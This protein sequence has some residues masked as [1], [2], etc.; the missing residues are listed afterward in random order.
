MDGFVQLEQ[1]TPSETRPH[2]TPP[3]TP[4]PADDL[5]RSPV[6]ARVLLVDD[7]ETTCEVL[8]SVLVGAGHEAAWDSD[9]EKALRR[10]AEEEFDVVLTDLSM[11]GMDG[12]QLCARIRELN[13]NLPVIVFTGRASIDAAVGALRAGA[14]DFLQ[15]PVEANLMIPA[16]VRAAKL[17]SLDREVK[18]LR[19]ALDDAQQFGPL[20]GRSRAMETMFSLI[21]RVAESDASVLIVGESG[22]GKELVAR[23]IHDRSRRK[24]GPFVAVNCAAVPPTLIESELFGHMR[25]A[26]TDAKNDHEGLFAQANGGTLFLDEVG[27]LPL[28]MQPKLLRVLQERKVRPVGGR[29]EIDLDVRI[30]TA[31]NRDLETAVA[32]SRFREDLLYRIDVV[33]VE[34]PALRERGR[35]ILLL[36]QHFAEKSAAAMGKADQGT[37]AIDPTVAERLLNYDWPGNVRELEN[38]MDRAVALAR[39]NRIVVEDLPQKVRDHQAKDVVVSTEDPRRLMT[40]EELERRYIS[41]VLEMLGGNKTQAA[42]VLGVDRRT[43]YRRL[44]RHGLMG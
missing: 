31:T 34:L 10:V 40:L 18:R 4:A 22:T 33:R 9:A 42:R 17:R 43:L 27:E 39:G 23:A 19:R 36:A 26:F 38:C 6:R 21:G 41:R 11:H 32:E 25:G 12:L 7:D 8:S 30:L 5:D 20:I 35:D 24:D 28:D 16:V 13:P 3:T 1:P 37:P 14:F 2:T 44:A 15:K 29:K